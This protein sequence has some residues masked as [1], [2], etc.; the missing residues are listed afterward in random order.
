M[1]ALALFLQ[2]VVLGL[3]VLVPWRLARA[4]RAALHAIPANPTLPAMPAPGSGG[5]DSAD[6]RRIWALVATPLLLAAALA[7]LYTIGLRLDAA[8]AWGIRWPPA[9]IPA[10]AILLSGLTVGLGDLLLFAGYRKLEPAG[11]RV[12]SL[13]GA[14]LLLAASLAGELL[15]LGRGPGATIAAILAAALCRVPLALAAGEASSGPV[16][17]LA[18]LAGAAL[19]CSLFAF[20][21]A[22]RATL[23]ADLLTLGAA[24]FLLLAA[25]L[26]PLSLR[27]PAALAGVLLAAF[28]LDRTSDLQAAFEPRATI[29]DILLAEP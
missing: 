11:W 5:P 22:L 9:S 29:P 27:R 7:A 25:R 4:A 3:H 16:R 6:S 15:R 14:I 21:T 23:G 12:C 20:S 13:L 26:L 1:S 19:P 18:P 8:L 24:S 17:W 2:L 28:F 10:F